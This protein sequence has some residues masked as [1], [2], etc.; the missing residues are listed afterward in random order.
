M[1]TLSHEQ[2]TP[3]Q[4]NSNSEYTSSK[5]LYKQN[6]NKI[7]MRKLKNT[8]TDLKYLKQNDPSNTK[9]TN[10][11]NALISLTSQFYKKTRP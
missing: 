11:I 4:I 1:I 6:I 7:I 9:E 10:Q 5:D 2:L 3:I 8:A